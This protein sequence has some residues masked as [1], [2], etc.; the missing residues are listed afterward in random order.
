M[1]KDVE[2]KKAALKAAKDT[3]HAAQASLKEKQDALAGVEAKLKELEDKQNA[4]LAQKKAL[5]EESDLC[6]GRM[7]RAGKLTNALGS[8]KIRWKENV[9]KLTDAINECVGSVF[10]AAAFIG[11]LAPFDGSFREKITQGW[12]TKCQEYNIPVAPIFSLYEIMA[13]PVDVRQWH[14]D[15]LPYD[16]LSVENGIVVKVSRRWS[17]MIDPQ[18][19]A[20]YWIGRMEK[21]AGLKVWP[22][23]PD[24]SPNVD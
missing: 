5:Q 21:A 6:T 10:L 3:L 13:D 15:G 24:P 7:E 12:V 16:S 22:Q 11:Y 1:A 23:H 14:I 4:T 17:M 20:R 19:Q 9:A 8:E 18:G 2:P